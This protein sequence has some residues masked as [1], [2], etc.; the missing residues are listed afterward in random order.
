MNLKH[1]IPAGILAAFSG[2]VIWASLQ[3]ELS[4]PMIVGESMQPRAFPMFLMVLNLV[5][6]AGLIVQTHKSPP[7]RKE[8]AP[9]ATWG[10]MA[11]MGVF[12]GLTEWL[13]MFI[14]IAVVMFA[15]C[16][17]WGE[18]RIPVAL[19]VALITPISVF[20]LF[21]QVLRVRF[22]RGVLTNWYYG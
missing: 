10:T 13:D 17:M 12:Y 18:R 14:G 16:L 19:S 9:F 8:P 22:P 5:L 21:D 1:H 15:M 6:L 4:P 11:L 2:V 7:K 3:L 20:V